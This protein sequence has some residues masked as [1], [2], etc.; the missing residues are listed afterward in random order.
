MRDAHYGVVGEEGG[1]ERERV[2]RVNAC[3]RCVVDVSR[4][5]CRETRVARGK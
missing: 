3:S 4:A 5:N 2:K 1:T